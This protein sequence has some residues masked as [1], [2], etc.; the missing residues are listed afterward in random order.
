MNLCHSNGV[1]S[2]LTGGERWTAEDFPAD[3]IPP[4]DFSDVDDQ[5]LIL[6]SFYFDE[7]D[8]FNPP[9]FESLPGEEYISL[10]SPA[11]DCTFTITPKNS[12]ERIYAAFF[13]I[14]YVVS[15]YDENHYLNSQNITDVTTDMTTCG[16]NYFSI[17]GVRKCGMIDFNVLTDPEYDGDFLKFNELAGAGESVEFELK[18]DAGIQAFFMINI[19]TGTAPPQLDGPGSRSIMPSQEIAN[20]Y[21]PGFEIENFI[22]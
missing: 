3:V 16:N 20:K 7:T 13:P 11:S 4:E 18:T 15:V 21:F 17:N 1:N 19:Y 14:F 10:V 2:F 5:F 9:D 12:D 6:P 22:F 8:E